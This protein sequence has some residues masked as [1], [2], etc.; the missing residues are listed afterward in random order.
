MIFL[1]NIIILIIISLLPLLGFYFGMV[2]QYNFS[3]FGTVIMAREI[4]KDIFAIG[5]PIISF[6]FA[7]E[8]YDRWKIERLIQMHINL[9]NQRYSYYDKN[10]DKNDDKTVKNSVKYGTDY[11][12][13]LELIADLTLKNKLDQELMREHFKTWYNVVEDEGWMEIINQE[14]LKEE[15]AYRKLLELAK[16]YGFKQYVENKEDI[17]EKS[18]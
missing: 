5:I 3:T 1:K 6:V 11:L 12:N 2:T 13:E 4:I 17:N 14:I 15:M 8:A 9:K 18:K 10:D 7:Y 16:V